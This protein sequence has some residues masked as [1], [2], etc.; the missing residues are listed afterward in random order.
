MK[1]VT[2]GGASMS[3]IQVKSSFA[4]DTLCFLQKRLLNDTKWMNEK[5]IEEIKYINDLLP[6]D[7]ED[8]CIGMSNICLIIS[9]YFD[10]D[11]EGLTLDDLID[12]FKDPETIEKVVKEKIKDGFTASY[13]YPVLGWLN[14]GFADLY[15]KNLTAL[16]SIEFD[17]L[18]SER[19]MPMVYTEME[20]KNNEVSSYDAD[21]LFQN[22]SLLKKSSTIA[23]ANIYVSFFSAPTAFALYGA[24]FLTCFCPAGAVDFYSIVAH[25]LMHGF[26]SKELTSLYRNHVESN[27]KL[28][29]CHRALIEDWSSGDEEEFVMAAEYYL[30]YLSGNYSKEQLLAKATKRY[31]GNC[32]TSIVVF[33][34]LLQEPEPLQNYDRWLIEQFRKNNLSNHN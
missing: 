29:S 33:E 20:Q 24:S 6:N 34:L 11:L 22:I 3:Y 9:A 14:D 4:L 2:K 19:I 23:S 7:F 17:R 15:V 31:G 5:Q 26:A 30:C 12:V 25:E 27:E 16:K 10:N 32:P 21:K 13:I 18:Y 8:N 28:R 1:M